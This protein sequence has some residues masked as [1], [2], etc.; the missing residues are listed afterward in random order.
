M[1]CGMIIVSSRGISAFL[2][3][4]LVGGASHPHLPHHHRMNVSL[5]PPTFALMSSG[6]AL[7][8]GLWSLN[9]SSP[10]RQA[11]PRSHHWRFGS[12]DLPLVRSPSTL[13]CGLL[14]AWLQ[15]MPWNW[16]AATSGHWLNPA[17]PLEILL[18]KHP[19]ELQLNC[20]SSSRT[21]LLFS[22]RLPPGNQQ[23]HIILSFAFSRGHRLC[24]LPL[25]GAL[26][27]AS[28]FRLLLAYQP[29]LPRAL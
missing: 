27:S 24:H 20:G 22:P 29:R 1:K 14:S 17:P 12:F 28:T 18:S 6:T 21:L 25:S 23:G 13:I 4:A 11:L 16:V 19:G 15:Y 9:S 26:S 7:C 10:Y 8:P 3:P 5:G 2:A